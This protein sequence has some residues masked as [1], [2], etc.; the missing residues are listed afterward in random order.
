MPSCV[1]RGRL[2]DARAWGRDGET[3]AVIVLE[4]HAPESNIKIVRRTVLPANVRNPSNF[5]YG[6]PSAPPAE[7]REREFD[8]SE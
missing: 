4:A 7:Q 1:K 8:V 5:T 3:I 2:A 6:T